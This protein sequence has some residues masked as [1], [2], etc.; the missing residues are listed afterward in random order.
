MLR[1]LNYNSRLYRNIEDP[2]ID[3][4][5]FVCVCSSSLLPIVSAIIGPRSGLCQPSITMPHSGSIHVVGY[6]T[7]SLMS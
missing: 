4:L 2:W 1:I 3:S 7:S 5:I 6:P